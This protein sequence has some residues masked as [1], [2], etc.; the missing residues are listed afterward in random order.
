MRLFTGIILLLLP[1]IA[2]SQ[3]AS[4]KDGKVYNGDKV[5]CYY[6]ESGKRISTMM[7]EATDIMNPL[8]YPEA[9]NDPFKDYAFGGEYQHFITAKAKILASPKEAFMVYYYSITIAGIPRELNIR[10]HPLLMRTLAQDIVKYD[11]VQNGFLNEKHAHKLLD[12]W[13]EKSS[14]LSRQQLTQGIASNYNSTTGK[15]RERPSTINIKIEGDRIYKDDSLFAIY[16]LDKHL[17][18]GNT[19][20]S[21]KGSN[22]YKIST[23]GGYLLGWVSV[24]ILRSSFFL[25]PAGEKESLAVVTTDRDEQKIITSAVKVLIVHNAAKQAAK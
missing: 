3:A 15:E 7:L 2:F 5:Y 17:G 6:K 12:K 19:W 11:V 1:A 13:E 20:G 4:M 18:G 24:P 8:L 9:N 16:E 10:Y 14:K 21:K 22:L 25:L 23:P